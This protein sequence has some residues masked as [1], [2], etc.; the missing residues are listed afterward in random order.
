MQPLQAQ[1]SAPQGFG[2]RIPSMASNFQEA[3]T[4]F[5]EAARANAA[6]NPAPAP[7]QA[8]EAQQAQQAQQAV[9]QAWQSMPYLQL[10]Q[11]MDSRQLQSLSTVSAS[12]PP[13][14]ERHTGQHHWPP[15]KMTSLLGQPHALLQLKGRTLR[16]AVHV[17]M[18]ELLT[19]PCR[20]Y[21]GSLNR[22]QASEELGGCS[23]S[24]AGAC[25][26][27]AAAQQRLLRRSRQPR[28]CVLL[29]RLHHPPVSFIR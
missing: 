21:Q 9:Q 19:W 23:S 4:S 16:L 25:R 8:H 12:P 7:A 1:G 13:S 2:S 20:L 6:Y 11:S 3:A 15:H 17:K 27:Q 29:P 14:A 28:R 26:P 24:L 10:L 22:P 5:L 18:A